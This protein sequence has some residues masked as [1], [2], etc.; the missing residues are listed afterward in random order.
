MS[1]T[2]RIEGLLRKA[3]YRLSPTMRRTVRRAVFLPIDLLRRRD[4][5]APPRGRIFIGSGDFIQRGKEQIHL[6]RLH[7]GLQPSH[8]VLDVGSG[9]GRTAVALKGF[10]DSNGSYD[11][12]D[13]V[14]EG[15]DWCR[16]NITRSHPN[17]RFVHVDLVNDLY[18]LNGPEA[19]TFRF[20]YADGRFD[21][22]FLFSVFTHMTLPDV[23][24]YL[25]E[26]ARVLKP[27]GICLATFFLYEQDT[28]V[29]LADHFPVPGNGFRLMDAKVTGAN[30]AFRLSTLDALT[31]SA[32]LDRTGLFEGYWRGSAYKQEGHEFQDV[33]LFRKG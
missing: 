6:L 16:A 28:D 27:G 21:V 9:I 31:R 8:H 2:D 22:V 26:I 13:V 10:L 18:N 11:G 20:P 30:I 23:Q 33:V 5:S 12:F 3:Y 25:N 29:H 32:G 1:F 14:K 19:N 7:A 24:H 17:F 4:P 15:V